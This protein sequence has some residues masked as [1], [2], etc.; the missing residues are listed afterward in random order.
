M[1]KL[2]CN[3]FGIDRI[4]VPNQTGRLGRLVVGD[5]LL[6]GDL[7]LEVKDRTVVA[8]N[9]TESK[10][11]LVL[12]GVFEAPV[13]RYELSLI[14]R[15]VPRVCLL[16][17]LRLVNDPSKCEETEIGDDDMILLPRKKLIRCLTD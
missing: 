14:A 1:W 5:Q 6:W 2:L 17:K 12:E 3:W 10:V 13:V 7:I 4:R 9:E 15:S 8:E 11:L 16:G